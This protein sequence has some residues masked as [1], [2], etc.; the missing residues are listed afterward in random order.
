[1]KKTPVFSTLLLILLAVCNTSL[2]AAKDNQNTSATF[3][4]EQIFAAGEP[5]AALACDDTGNVYLATVSGNIL[6]ITSAKKKQK[7]ISGLKKG[8]YSQ[9][10]LAIL[11][12]GELLT[13]DYQNGQDALVKIDLG[14][15]KTVLASFNDYLTA[16]ATDA[17]GRI[18]LGFWSAEGK[19]TINSRQYLEA[20]DNIRGWVMELG[21]D[22]TLKPLFEGGLPITL[23]A[24]GD[25][26]LYAAFW[27]D[28]GPFAPA[29]KDYRV[30]D[31]RITFFKLLSTGCII[32]TLSTA[33]GQTDTLLT[34]QLN[35]VSAMAIDKND[36]LNFGEIST[37][38]ELL[39]AF[40]ATQDGQSGLYRVKEDGTPRLISVND[41]IV[42][43]ING[44]AS[45][46]Q[47]LYF[48]TSTGKIY[49]VP[50]Q[51]A[52]ASE[53]LIEAALNMSPNEINTLLK[54]GADI[55]TT[56]KSDRTPL[57][58]ALFNLK[59]DNAKLLIDKGADINTPD[60]EGM[61]PL[62]YA[63][64]NSQTAE[65]AKLLIDRGVDINARSKDNSTPLMFALENKQAENAQLLID[66]GADINAKD[67]DGWTPLLV[68]LRYGQPDYAR[69]LIDKG[70]D[71]NGN[72]N[73]WTPLMLALSYGQP[74]NAKFLIDKGADINAKNNGVTPLM[75]AL[76]NKQ[77]ENAEYLIEKGADIN[78]VDN[79][80]A[81]VLMYAICYSNPEL[82]QLITAKGADIN[83]RDKHN[84][85]PLMYALY[86]FQRVNTDLLI[87]KGADLNTRDS[88]GQT[89][90]IY[91][92]ANY[93]LEI[94]LD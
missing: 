53:L 37:Q 31:N 81:T 88:H 13:N 67:N 68:A 66:K 86:N 80:N 49:R 73:N 29:I 79:N 9:R 10:V 76:L 51:T 36:S 42:H 48:A 30:Y 64:N 69:I 34:K 84:T 28:K 83:A 75:M 4:A 45:S 62:M 2:Y 32:K 87:Q 55:N 14:G 89:P 19:L 91:A 82:V 5:V 39:F 17:Q 22:G 74:E 90:V 20:A 43:N 24:C 54:A 33:Q 47:Y 57:M 72:M 18:F 38:N 50:L 41:K 26:R 25:G 8:P 15:H 71:I 93:E 65:A 27:G 77:P 35:A 1:M 21:T 52:R 56:G 12:S 60:N 61:T 58:D 44:I 23:T 7:L 11:P 6:Q 85:T 46:D 16:L 40:G 94:A 63:L 92:L 70:A 78:A 59:T 3:S